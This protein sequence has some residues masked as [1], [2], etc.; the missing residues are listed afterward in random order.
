[1]THENEGQ[2]RQ[3]ERQSFLQNVE[4]KSSIGGTEAS[5]STKTKNPIAKVDISVGAV[6]LNPSAIRVI[7]RRLRDEMS[8]N[9]VLRERFFEDPKAVLGSVGLNEEIQT[10]LLRSEVDFQD[11]PFFGARLGDWCITTQCCCT[12]CCLTC[13]FSAF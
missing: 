8:R 10:E 4:G 13:W 9:K 5:I 6:A 1:M 2:E 12:S 11:S 3:E 7:T